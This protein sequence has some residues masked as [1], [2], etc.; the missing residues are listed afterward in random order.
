MMMEAP[1]PRGGFY[2]GNR[3]LLDPF[4]PV[5]TGSFQVGQRQSARSP[6]AGQM[7]CYGGPGKLPSQL[8]TSDSRAIR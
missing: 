3:P 2:S 8:M 5:M 4:R 1:L 6:I 7:S